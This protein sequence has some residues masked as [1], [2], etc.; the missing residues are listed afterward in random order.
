MIK[1]VNDTIDKKDIDELVI[2][3]QTYPYPRLTKGELTIELEKKWSNFLGRKYS[4]YL[5]SGSSANLAMAYALLQS[6]YLKNKKIVFPDVSWVTTISPFIQLGYEPIVCDIEMDTLGINIEALE[7]IFEKEKPATLIIVHVLGTPNKMTEIM[8]LCLKYDVIL[9]EDS[10]ESIGSTYE[11]IQTGCFGSM[12][13]FSLYMGH[14]MSVSPKTP[15]PYL[16]ENNIFNIENIDEIYNKYNSDV[17]KIKILSF[18]E[19]YKTIYVSPDHILKHKIDNKKIFQLKLFNNR[20][21]ELTEDHSVFKYDKEKSDIS[22]VKGCDIKLDDYIFVPTKIQRPH[23]KKELDFLNFCKKMKNEFFVIDYD[24]KDLDDI[25]FKWNSKENKQKYNWKKRKILPIEYLKTDKNDLKIA[26]KRTPRDKYIPVKYKINKELCRLIG[27]FLAEGSYG[28]SSLNFSFDI[29]EK[30]YIDDVTNSIKSIFGLNSYKNFNENTNSC[31]IKVSSET[32]KIVF[33]DFFNIKSGAS[34]KRIPSFIFHSSNECIISFL[35]AY[36]SG[37]GTIKGK[38]RISVTSVSEKLITDISYLCNIIGLNGGLITINNK[39]ERKFKNSNKISNVKPQYQFVLNNITFNNDGE[40]IFNESYKKI[41]LY[42]IKENL[43]KFKNGD[44]IPIKI[45]SIEEI[46]P[47]YEYVFDFSVKNLENF[48]G[49][50]QPICLHNSTI[51]GGF[52]STDDVKLY[53][54]LMSIRSHGWD[55]DWSSE[56]KQK[57]R[58]KYSVDDFK[59][60]YT[61]YYPG[62]NLRSTDLQAFI[63]LRQIDKL[64]FIIN[65][66]NEN[67][68]LYDNLIEN[69]YWKLSPPKNCFI[70]NFAYPIIHPRIKEIVKSLNEAD[71]ETRPLI[72]GAITKQPFWLDLYGENKDML[73][74]VLVDKYG[75]YLP[76]NHQISKDEISYICYIINRFTT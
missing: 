52:V 29:K 9:L 20:I 31:N 54:I 58:E 30:E 7:K 65:K 36:F 73:N 64:E 23:V 15:I 34:N 72:C 41:N 21:V 38:N 46:S 11:N 75:L 27:Y 39:K 74:S 49:G 26:K 25:H 16:D 2:W 40:I 12:S 1:L 13:S 47:E 55:R 37:D 56:Y 59:S 14:H 10:C 70:S 61:F 57:M 18:D 45:R 3:L 4:V 66:R 22:I 35:Y 33:K 8:D 5:N 62:F 19:N 6:G 32:L 69:Q 43:D 53:N 68:K 17:S 24:I 28:D 44:I 71:I 60:L 50:N 67:F 51:E 63:G 42:G 48:V 76:N